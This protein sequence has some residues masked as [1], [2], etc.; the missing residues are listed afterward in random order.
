MGAASKATEKLKSVVE[1]R[2]LSSGG[3]KDLATEVAGSFADAVSGKSEQSGG[4]GKAEQ[5]G[6]KNTSAGAQ[7]AAGGSKT[8]NNNSNTSSP[9]FS[10]TTS[11]PGSGGMR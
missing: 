9:S 7:N 2:G 10:K 4:S 11:N 3:L 5:S 8:S 6:M 1:E